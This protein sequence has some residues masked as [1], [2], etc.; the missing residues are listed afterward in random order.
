M[1][2]VIVELPHVLRVGIRRKPAVVPMRRLNSMKVSSALRSTARREPSRLAKSPRRSRSLRTSP[3]S[4]EEIAHGAG[5]VGF[6]LNG[7]VP[8]QNLRRR[9]AILYVIQVDVRFCGHWAPPSLFRADGCAPRSIPPA[10]RRVSLRDGGQAKRKTQAS[11]GLGLPW[12][13]GKQQTWPKYTATAAKAEGRYRCCGGEG[14]SRYQGG[15]EHGP[16]GCRGRLCKT[17][18]Q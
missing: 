13:G 16:G 1:G 6:R 3:V 17:H 14:V 18:I 12:H 10:R 5:D 7:I 11:E 2:Q 15:F 8:R 9:I 4:D